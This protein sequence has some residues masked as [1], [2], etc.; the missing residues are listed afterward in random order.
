[1]DGCPLLPLLCSIVLE[2][3][4][5]AIRQEKEINGIPIREEEI[6]LSLLADDMVL[7]IENLKDF[8]KKLLELIYEFSKIAGY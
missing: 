6:K 5:T 8:T 7:Y 3:L 1:M 2:V 4:I